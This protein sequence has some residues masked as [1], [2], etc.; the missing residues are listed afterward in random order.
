MPG[1]YNPFLLEPRKGG[2]M[3]ADDECVPLRGGRDWS[4]DRQ[5]EVVRRL[6]DSIILGL[7]TVSKAIGKEQNNSKRAEGGR[8]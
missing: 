1:P 3:L 7:R 2:F 5:K 4:A 6:V 8:E